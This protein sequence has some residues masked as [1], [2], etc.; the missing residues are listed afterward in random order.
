MVVFVIVLAFLIGIPG[1][2]S[3]A[4]HL[5]RLAD[6]IIEASDDADA[7]TDEKPYRTSTERV[8]DPEAGKRKANDRCRQ[9][10]AH[11]A[12]A[13]ENATGLIGLGI[14][15]SPGVHGD[16]MLSPEALRSADLCGI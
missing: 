16:A 2:P 5:Q 6:E 4:A 8:V 7:D 13:Q 3:F 1:Q 10:E 12:V 15:V 14:V 11:S 9:L